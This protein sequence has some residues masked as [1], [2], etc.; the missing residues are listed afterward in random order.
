MTL[1]D[2]FIIA[3]TQGVTEFLP[4]SSSG[5]LVL[6]QSF[7]GLQDIPVL[8]NLILHLGTVC[9]TIAV[10]YRIL[11]NILKDLILWLKV[12]KEA[13]KNLIVR[14]NVKLFFYILFSTLVTGLLGFLFSDPLHDFF[15]RPGIVPFLMVITGIILFITRFCMYGRKEI[16]DINLDYPLVIG[17]AQAFAMLPGIS[18]SGV[19]ISAGLFMSATRQFSGMY[20]FILSIPSILGASLVEIILSGQVLHK[21]IGQG[22]IIF[23][24]IMSFIIGYASL[25]ILIQFLTRGKLY[26]FSY[27]C[28]GFAVTVIILLFF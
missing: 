9:A 22:V 8:F 3:V 12:E 6:L 21:N 18:R 1:F 5:H 26:Y 13:R 28:I 25:R 17:T 14:G 2:A 15:Q 27:Y 7:L 10:Y 19:T 11:W 23:S 4:I 20:S 24:F 16:K